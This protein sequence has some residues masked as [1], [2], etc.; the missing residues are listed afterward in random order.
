MAPTLPW[1]NPD[2]KYRRKRSCLEDVNRG[3]HMIN[4]INMWKPSK[5]EDK[6]I[7]YRPV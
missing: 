6:M 7:L 3:F 5:V 1:I 2:M 4:M